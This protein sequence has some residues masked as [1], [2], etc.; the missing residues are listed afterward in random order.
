MVWPLLTSLNSSQNVT[1]LQP[2]HC[3]PSAQ[4]L[5]VSQTGQAFLLPS[6]CTCCSLY[7]K[8][9]PSSSFL[10]CIS[11]LMSPPPGSPPGQPPTSPTK[12]R[13][14]LWAPTVPRIP[15]PSPDPSS[16]HCL[17]HPSTRL[18][19]SSMCPQPHRARGRCSGNGCRRNNPESRLSRKS[20]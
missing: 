20:L 19:Q 14:P 8:Y 11:A 17:A 3:K 2:F 5:L 13:N 6:H 15:Y 16:H 1:F 9:F 4:V 10:L 18:A 7:Q 12:I